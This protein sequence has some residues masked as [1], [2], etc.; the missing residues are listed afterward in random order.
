MSLHG[1]T[2]RLSEARRVAIFGGTHGNEMSGVAL[3][4]L[5]IKNGADIQRRGADI[6]PFITNPRA[7][8]KCVRYVDTDLNRA[9]THENLR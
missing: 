2:A 8:E 9:F 6:K 4:N 1:S 3:V 5:W 7:V